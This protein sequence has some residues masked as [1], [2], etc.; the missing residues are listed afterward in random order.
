MNERGKNSIQR[1]FFYSTALLFH[2]FPFSINLFVIGKLPFS[3][4]YTCK[5]NKKFKKKYGIKQNNTLKLLNQN[6]DENKTKQK[7]RK[8]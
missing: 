2:L 1:L 6:L 4:I 3:T 8:V 7:K 5:R